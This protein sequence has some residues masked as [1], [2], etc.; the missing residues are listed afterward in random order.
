MTTMIKWHGAHHGH[1]GHG[2]HMMADFKQRS[3]SF[4]IIYPLA[5]IAPILMHLVIIL[6]FRQGLLEWSCC[7]CILYGGKPS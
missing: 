7:Y 3:G 5:I 2:A 6:I 4:G 1:D